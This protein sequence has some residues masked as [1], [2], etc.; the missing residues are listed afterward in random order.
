ME[1]INNNNQFWDT[2]F[3]NFYVW[4]HIE[5][6]YIVAPNLRLA[7]WKMSLDKEHN[8]MHWREQLLLLIHSN[9]AKCKPITHPSACLGK[10][11]SS[12]C[13]PWS[14]EWWFPQCS[15]WR[16]VKY[17]ST[18]LSNPSQVISYSKSHICVRALVPDTRGQSLWSLSLSSEINPNST[19]YSPSSTDKPVKTA[20]RAL[21]F[22]LEH[23]I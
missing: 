13:F 23:P 2:V 5:N 6:W 14:T 11:I 17:Q 10:R 1:Q 12:P 19:T 16:L 18:L 15:L 3:S 20:F 8:K 4:T 21:Q 7:H 22:K 9:Q